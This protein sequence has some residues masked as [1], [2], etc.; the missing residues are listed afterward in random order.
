MTKAKP[1]LLRLTTVP[2]SLRLLL[3]GQPRY[4]QDHGLQVIIGSAEGPEREMVIAAEGVPHELIPFTRAITPVQDLKCLG[5]LVRFMRREKPNIVHTHTPKAGLLGMLAARIAGVPVRI[6]TIAGL[7]F[8]TATGKR[9]QLLIAME[10][11]TYAAAQ[12]VW[13]NSHGI[14]EYMREQQLCPERKLSLIGEGSTNGIDLDVF[15]PD[16]VTEEAVARVREQIGYEAEGTYVMAIGR[17]VQDKGIAELLEAFDRLKGDFPSLRL[18]LVGP[19]ERERPEETLS[20]E[21]L[22]QIDTDPAITHI[23]WTDNVAAYLQ[24]ADVLVHASYREGFPNVPL[25]AGA[26][27]CPIVCSAIPGNV[28]IVTDGQT[29]RTFPVGDAGALESRLRET[30][31][32]PQKSQDMAEALRRKVEANFDR[33]VIHRLLLERYRSLLNHAV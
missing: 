31:T 13:P 27:E 10:K 9:R 11:L 2:I 21:A 28:D 30:L 5:Q 33:K 8:M 14:M 20:A 18:V 26:M 16:R 19:L 3:T 12:H 24:V 6:H 17:I 25:Q 32:Q 29:G 7:P 23:G 22:A 4:M 15:S 1:K